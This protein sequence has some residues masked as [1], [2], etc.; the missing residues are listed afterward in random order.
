MTSLN[1]IYH[2]TTAP[3]GRRAYFC[4]KQ[5]FSV[6]WSVCLSA[7][8]SHDWRNFLCISPVAM[9]WSSF[10]GVVIFY[11]FLV[12]WVRYFLMVGPVSA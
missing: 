8:I 2:L 9:S 11:A 10:D 6:G 12:L 4:D 7:H 1:T 5:C 3:T